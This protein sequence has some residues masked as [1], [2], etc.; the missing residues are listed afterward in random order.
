MAK[1]L[2]H[3]DKVS[4]TLAAAILLPAMTDGP[5]PVEE[6]VLAAHNDE[7]ASL[8][9]PALT[10]DPRLAA[11]AQIW[12]DYLAVTGK[13]EHSP[14]TADRPREGEN[15]WGGTKHAFSP[16]SMVDL[17]ITEKVHYVD[18]VFPQNSRS[19]RV[20]DVSHYTQLI[21]KATTHVGCGIAR[22]EQEEILVCRYSSPGNI[23]GQ[24]PV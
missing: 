20:Q 3:T 15:I 5:D 4:V 21:W 19:G 23:I 8:G 6:R 17:W 2:S 22:G 24:R 7:R 14:D 13:F 12:A 11:G 16:E 1:R 9:S 10:W 18:G